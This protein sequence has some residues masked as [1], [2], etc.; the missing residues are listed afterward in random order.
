M[1]LEKFDRFEK[2]CIQCHDGPDADTIGSAYGLYDYFKSRGKEV[3]IIYGGAS[4]I[5]KPGLTLMVKSLSIPV[6]YV[7]KLPACDVLITADCQYGGGNVTRFPAPRVGMVDHHPACVEMNEYCCV[8]TDCGSC[9]TV[10]WRLLKEAGYDFGANE[11]VSTALY[12]GLFTD[13]GHLS[14]IHQ[15]DDREMRDTLSVN[16]D[17]LDAMI[18]SNLSR[19]ELQ[20]AGEALTHYFYDEKSRFA[21]THALPCDPNLLGVISDMVIQAAGIDSCVAYSESAIG[22]KLSVRNCAP[23][24]TAEE[25]VKAIADGIG[26]GGGHRNKAGGFVQKQM[27][28]EGYGR[29]EFE[30]VLCSRIRNYIQNKR[31]EEQPA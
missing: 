15:P 6:E 7:E 9:C 12:Y 5:T 17:L 28:E 19:Q 25:M 21:I 18:N 1:F 8:R 4:R 16:R 27:F 11:K 31:R 14:E 30:D 13:T 29:R 24:L 10:V 3:T 22:Y 26:T 20:I 23:E 2:I